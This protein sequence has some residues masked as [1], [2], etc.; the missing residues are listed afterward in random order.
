MANDAKDKTEEK[1]DI[2]IRLLALS[3]VKETKSMKDKILFLGGAGLPPKE[4]AEL[5]QTTPNHV[6]VALSQARKSKKAASKGS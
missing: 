5:L 2:L 4:I 3:L 6:N 1:L